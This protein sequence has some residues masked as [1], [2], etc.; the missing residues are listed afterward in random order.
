MVVANRPAPGRA[1]VATLD[2]RRSTPFFSASVAIKVPHDQPA[3]A[4]R[5]SAR[6][7]VVRRG[8]VTGSDCPDAARS[9]AA[10]TGSATASAGAALAAAGGDAGSDVD[11]GALA[12]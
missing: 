6:I 3:S 4:S 1:P 12:I 5:P 10:G 2:T 11:I 8:N 7:S 9:G